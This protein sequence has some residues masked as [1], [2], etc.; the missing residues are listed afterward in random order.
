M[1]GYL[2]SL[3]EAGVIERRG[4]GGCAGGAG[5][6][7]TP[8]GC[9][10][11]QVAEVLAAWLA[12]SPQGPIELGTDEAKNAI[13][14]FAD[15]WSAGVVDALASRSLSLT[16]LD[17]VIA[18]LSYPALERRLMAMRLFGLV[19]TV[20]GE[21]RSTPYAISDW[22]R[23]AIASLAAAARW[24]RRRRSQPL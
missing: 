13:K 7:L 11:L 10:L 14:A 24:E 19:E 15:G 21:G 4:R 12:E 17:R 20:D 6:E 3:T 8:S 5:Y 22:L 1:R 16:E 2:R 9:A 23:G 18:T